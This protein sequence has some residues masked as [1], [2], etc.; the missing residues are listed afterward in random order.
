M[1][2]DES[3][4]WQRLN[5][6]G[7]VSGKSPIVAADDTPWFVRAMLG[8]AGWIGAV[9]LL[10]WVGIAFRAVFESQELAMMAGLMACGAA[11]MLFRAKPDSDFAG[12]FA[13]AT[14][15]TGQA[16]VMVSVAKSFNQA[17]PIALSM[18]VLQAVL[19]AAM[20]S[21]LHRVWS[22]AAC[23]A[24]LMAAL[25]DLKTGSVAAGLLS[26][27]CAAAWLAEL[28]QAEYGKMIRA[29]SYGLTL[30]LIGAAIISPRFAHP[31]ELEVLADAALRGAALVWVV[32]EVLRR[33]AIDPFAN[34]GSRLLLASGLLAVAGL[35]APGLAPATM[36]LLLGFAHG[37]VTLA[38][39]GVAALLGYLSTYYFQLQMTLLQKSI[40][41]ATTGTGLLLARMMLRRLWPTEEVPRA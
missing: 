7:L 40:L 29:G 39:L 11:A 2:S 9:F 16:L 25:Y 12:Q 32:Y 38:G 34:S 5:R 17:T 33:E 13:F 19:F 36:I 35:K 21:F 22:S 6:E 18:A 14:S 4:L 23:A 30:A 28:K 24:A 3:A 8:I 15:L 31:G 20:P 26:F 1:R 10:F 27:A 41:M 37:N